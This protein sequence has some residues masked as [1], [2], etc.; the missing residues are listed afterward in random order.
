LLKE[1]F[2]SQNIALTYVSVQNGHK[3][4]DISRKFYSTG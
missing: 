2:H 4:A 1:D 3:V